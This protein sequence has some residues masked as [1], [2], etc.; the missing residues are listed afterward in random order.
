MFVALSGDRPLKD[1]IRYV[2]ETLKDQ[3]TTVQGVGDIR[4]GGYVDPNLRVW[5]DADKMQENQL[6]VEDIL[7]AIGYQHADLPAGYIEAGPK[8]INVRVYGEASTPEQF[9]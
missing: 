2:N 7:N 4:L 3:F 1:F 8:E 5:L 6:T 9:E